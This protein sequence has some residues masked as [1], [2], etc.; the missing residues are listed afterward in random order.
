M[1]LDMSIISKA[2]FI[3]WDAIPSMTT[4]SRFFVVLL[5]KLE[6]LFHQLPLSP[7]LVRDGLNLSNWYMSAVG[8]SSPA[9]SGLSFHVDPLKDSIGFMSLILMDPELASDS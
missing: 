1:I 5:L 7:S 8:S 4:I 2:S 3:W 9:K 6:L